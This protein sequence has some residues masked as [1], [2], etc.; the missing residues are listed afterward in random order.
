MTNNRKP[1]IL[2]LSIIDLNFN[3]MEIE[4]TEQIAT[5]PKDTIQDT[6]VLIKLMEDTLK[7]L[8]AELSDQIDFGKTD[9]MYGKIAK[10]EAS[11]LNIKGNLAYDLLKD[12]GL[13]PADFGE[14]SVKLTEKQ[15]EELVSQGILTTDQLDAIIS[16]TKY[17]TTR[18]TPS[19]DAKE[20]FELT[21]NT[22][23]FLLE[24]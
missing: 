8:K 12:Q 11:R 7:N 24:N 1:C 16:E 18:I 9:A 19:K 17:T 5:L 21:Y 22:K 13:D 3:S 20:I 23:Q 10:T 6:L 2:H 14:C 15:L 4:M